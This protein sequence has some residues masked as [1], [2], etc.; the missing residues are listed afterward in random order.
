[1]REKE[2]EIQIGR[3]KVQ[4]KFKLLPKGTEKELTK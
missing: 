2:G 4:G 3:K 1:V